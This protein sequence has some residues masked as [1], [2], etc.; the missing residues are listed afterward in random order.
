MAK[1]K[2][3]NP[4]KGGKVGSNEIFKMLVNFEYLFWVNNL[5]LKF[6]KYVINLKMILHMI[7]N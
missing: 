1:K 5:A 3:F 7:K 4:W 2:V 6:G